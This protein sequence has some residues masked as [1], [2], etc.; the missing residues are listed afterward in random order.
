[1]VIQGE[2]S[3]HYVASGHLV[4]L[5]GAALLAAPF[6]LGKLAVTGSPAPLLDGVMA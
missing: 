6:D 5:R 1:V 4:F 3:P 2:H